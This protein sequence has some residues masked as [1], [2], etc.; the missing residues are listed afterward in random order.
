[1]KRKCLINSQS[2]I[3]R[4]P[5]RL[6]ELKSY[7]AN[8]SVDVSFL[9][10]TS[11][12]N[13]IQETRKAL[14]EGFEQI[15]PIGGDGTLNAAVNGFFENRKP[16][17]EKALLVPT[18]EGTGCDYYKAVAGD[19]DWRKLVTEHKTKAVDIGE[20]DYL[21]APSPPVYFINIASLGVSADVVRRQKNLP[22]WLPPLLSYAIPAF[23][24]LFSMNPKSLKLQMDGKTE[25]DKY[26]NL[27]FAKGKTAGG[28]MKLGGGADWEDGKF[29]V[30]LFREMSLLES[31]PRF[32]KLFSGNLL[33]DSKITKE[34][35]SSV[36]VWAAEAIPVEYDGEPDGTT[37][38][39]FTVVPKSIQLCFPILPDY[40]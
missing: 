38:V 37:P 7:F 21:G 33:G 5:Q 23:A 31:L 25:Q 36:E 13:A 29:D 35:C 19:R 30:T 20:I 28:G 8:Q 40:T 2:R 24:S 12:E 1:M 15:I 3:G 22:A 9:V 34:L 16:I 4:D 39:R 27:F 6:S 26:L 11:R 10:T 18:N 17:N 14:H 32:A